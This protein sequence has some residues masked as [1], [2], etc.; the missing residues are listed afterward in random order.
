MK[1]VYAV[2]IPTCNGDCTGVEY[3]QFLFDQPPTRQDVI[4]VIDSMS[5]S[6]ENAYRIVELDRLILDLKHAIK[7]IWFWTMLDASL[8]SANTVVNV[9]VNINTIALFTWEKINVYTP[10][11]VK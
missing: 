3:N 5:L 6:D 1:N 9:K 8:D 10:N 4:D 7:Q 2:I 11:S